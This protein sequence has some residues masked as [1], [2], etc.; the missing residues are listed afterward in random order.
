MKEDFSD[1]YRALGFGLLVVSLLG[2]LLLLL[3]C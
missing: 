2:M 1:S 3:M